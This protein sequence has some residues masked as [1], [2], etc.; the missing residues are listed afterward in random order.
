LEEHGLGQDW[1]GHTWELQLHVLLG[2][3]DVEKKVCEVWLLLGLCLCEV[4][5]QHRGS[6]LKTMRWRATELQVLGAAW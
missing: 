3:E 5:N 1:A 4:Q 6:L 2:L